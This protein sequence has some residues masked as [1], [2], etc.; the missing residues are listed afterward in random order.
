MD[1]IALLIAAGTA[2]TIGLMIGMYIASLFAARKFQRIQH[3]SWLASER[4][5]KKAYHMTPKA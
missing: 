4:F 3:E 5:Y 2:F 1:S